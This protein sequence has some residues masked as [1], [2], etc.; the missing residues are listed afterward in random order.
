MA[1]R[2]L[3]NLKLKTRPII[4]CGGSGTRLWPESREKFPKQFIPVLKGKTLFD[5]TLE[6]LKSIH[7]TLTPIIITNEQ[8]K[9]L[10]KDSLNLQNFNAKIVLEPIGKNTTVAIYIASKISDKDENL[11][12]MPCDHYIGNNSLL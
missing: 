5:L 10:V 12:I 1:I 11:L 6:R 3:S 8:Y 2:K 7:Y 4:L 9:Y